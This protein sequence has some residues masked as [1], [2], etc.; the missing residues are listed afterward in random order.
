MSAVMQPTGNEVS[1]EALDEV[2]RSGRATSHYALVLTA[3][4]RHGPA[5]RHQIAERTGLPLSS[6][7]G[8]VHELLDADH[9]TVTGV[10][11]QREDPRPRQV[12]DLTAKGVAEWTRQQA[13]LGEGAADA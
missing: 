10:I 6:V 8:R 13:V 11:Q 4:M 2:R 1:R 12:L 3:I 5:T 9:L 7:C